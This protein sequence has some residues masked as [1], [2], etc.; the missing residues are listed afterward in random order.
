MKL[1]ASMLSHVYSFFETM[2]A[3]SIPFYGYNA[4]DVNDSKVTESV[5]FATAAFTYLLPK[6][7]NN[8]TGKD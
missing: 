6:T 2:A 1:I 4:I 8:E 3:E 5:A 7:Q